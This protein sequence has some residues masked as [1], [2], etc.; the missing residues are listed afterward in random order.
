MGMFSDHEQFIVES[1][2]KHWELFAP[3][4]PNAPLFFSEVTPKIPTQVQ[5][6]RTRIV[7]TLR[8]VC[9]NG[10]VTF[11]HARHSFANLLALRLIFPE[12]LDTYPAFAFDELWDARQTS[13]QLLKH[14]KPTRRAAWALAATLGHAHPQTTF[15]HYTHFLHDWANVHCQK[16]NPRAFEAEVRHRIAERNF[17]IE[18]CDADRAYPMAPPPRAAAVYA[19]LTPRVVLDAMKL[20]GRAVKLETVAWQLRLSPQSSA[21]LREAFTALQTPKPTRK[22]DLV[23]KA[24]AE[25]PREPRSQ[26]ARLIL[27]RPQTSWNRIDAVVGFRGSLGATDLHPC[28]QVADARQ[29]L[30]FSDEHLTQIDR[31]LASIGWSKN[32]V[33]V[34]EPNG[35]GLLMPAAAKDHGFKVIVGRDRSQKKLTNVK[36]EKSEDT[37]S[38]RGRKKKQAIHADVGTENQR[39]EPVFQ[40]EVAKVRIKGQPRLL[41]QIDRLAIVPATRYDEPIEAR[42]DKAVSRPE[43]VLI[44]LALHLA[45]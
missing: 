26:Y 14:D 38:A 22:P 19:Q 28:D 24:N 6:H 29:I 27:S 32:D 33:D 13:L 37:K 44:W 43:F 1:W 31:F 18:R 21:R 8:A 4:D 2:L 12:L 40:V 39:V 16:A 23:R 42:S 41:D 17:D 30:V 3:K 25:R 7:S 5:A 35:H 11:H 36:D 15:H 45:T 20:C 34:Y 10:D 9:S